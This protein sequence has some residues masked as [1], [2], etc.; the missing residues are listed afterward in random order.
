MFFSRSAYAG[1]QRYAARQETGDNTAEWG[2][3]EASIPMCLSLSVAGMAYLETLTVNCM[4]AAFQ[5]FFWSHAHIDTKRRKPW[6]YSAGK[7]SLTRATVRS[8]YTL[9]YETDQDGAHEAALV[10]V[11]RG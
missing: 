2:H 5:P 3:L 9:F 10:P 1:S 7:M 4:S 11:P 6:L 8:C